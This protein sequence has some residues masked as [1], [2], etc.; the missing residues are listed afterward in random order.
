MGHT[1]S[2]PS[3]CSLDERRSNVSENEQGTL[4]FEQVE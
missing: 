2:M 1:T 3:R 4:G